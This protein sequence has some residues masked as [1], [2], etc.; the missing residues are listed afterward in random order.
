MATKK[1]GKGTRVVERLRDPKPAERPKRPT[2]LD[3]PDVHDAFNE[4]VDEPGG[5]D[6]IL[7]GADARRRG[8]RFE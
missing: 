2:V 3:G 5:L 1:R 7:H 4:P 6:E 8:N